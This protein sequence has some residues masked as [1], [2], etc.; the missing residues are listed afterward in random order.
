MV[1]QL[2]NVVRRCEKLLTFMYRVA[3]LCCRAEK[4]ECS[5]EADLTAVETYTYVTPLTRGCHSDMCFR[6]SSY[7]LYSQSLSYNPGLY[8]VLC[9]AFWLIISLPEGIRSIKHA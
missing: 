3:M 8:A 2:Y 5:T 1:V 4:K 6:Y 7:A 9:A